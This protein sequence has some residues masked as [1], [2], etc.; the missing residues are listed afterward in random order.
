MKIISKKIS[1][2]PYKSRINGSLQSYNGCDNKTFSNYDVR[3][4]NH[5]YGMFPYDVMYDG[6]ILSYPTL[7]ERYYFCKKYKELLRYDSCSGEQVYA[8]AKEY[9]KHNIEY[10]TEL[11]YQ[12]YVDLDNTYTE[13][14]GNAFLSW[15]ESILY[16]G[17]ATYSNYSGENEPNDCGKIDNTAHILIPILFTN[18]I[19]DMGEYSIFCEDWEEG[20]VYNNGNIAIYDDNIWL[21]N[22]NDYGSIF[23]EK[24]KEFYFPQI[25][26][27]KHDYNYQWYEKS[28]GKITYSENQW[29]NYTDKNFN[30]NGQYDKI[31]ATTYS[32]KNGK[33]FYDAKA[34]DDM[35]DKHKIITN[36]LGFYVINNV[37]HKAFKQEYV[38]YEGEYS[39]V[40]E[41]DNY[42]QLNTKYCYIKG[43]KIYSRTTDD[44]KHYFYIDNKEYYIENG[45]FI[46]HNEFPIKISGNKVTINNITYNKIDGYSIIDGVIYYVS[47]NKLITFKYDGSEYGINSSLITL[48]GKNIT[49]A[50]ANSSGYSIDNNTIYVYK[51][52]N[53]YSINTMSGYTESKL[54]SFKSSLFTFDDMGNKLPGCLQ[55]NTSGGYKDVSEGYELDL[56]YKVGT[57]NNLT[58]IEFDENNNVKTFFGNKLAS[59]SFYYVDF[60]GKKISDTVI[61]CGK[62]DS[63]LTKINDSKNKLDTFK[64]NHKDDNY[65]AENHYSINENIRCNIKYHMGCL[66]DKDYNVI[67][68]NSGV[69]YEEEVTIIKKTHEYHMDDVTSYII[70]YYDF[71]YNETY[72]VL[73]EYSNKTTKIG[74]SYFSY[75]ID[76]LINPSSSYR[77]KYDGMVAAPVF[78]EEYKFGSSMRE[79]IE[80]NIYIDRGFSSSFER[81]LKMLDVKSMESLE[82]LGN[83]FYNI[84]EN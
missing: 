52:Y 68:N 38:N 2:E 22:G 42:Y 24:Y 70:Y 23:S 50:D 14:G 84:I 36:D 40:Y 57:V 76:D 34:K 33:I 30:Y 28:I 79:N 21:K 11:K 71:V 73:N 67:P 35:S 72:D 7:M 29:E 61:N 4:Q 9:Y 62:D 31:T 20:V 37:I 69:T 3:S 45:D 44:L 13:Y 1:L 12:E 47:G 65:I 51:P 16:G 74:K 56:P 43:Q 83:G 63:L 32:V 77:S 41:A 82:N 55:Q 15:C 60:Y 10:R 6:K 66:M 26:D 53:E 27:L 59:I 81:H 25:K 78:R 54:S 39:L 64:S 46:L 8:D 48:L 18:T 58:A 17:T 19:D 49:T 75:T 80:S 5:N